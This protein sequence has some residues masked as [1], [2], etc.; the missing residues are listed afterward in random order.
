M[1]SAIFAIS[2]FI[3]ICGLNGPMKAQGGKQSTSSVA[4]SNC[5]NRSKILGSGKYKSIVIPESNK[6]PVLICLIGRNYFA[7]QVTQSLDFSQAPEPEP[8]TVPVPSEICDLF[9]NGQVGFYE[10]GGD[11]LECENFTVKSNGKT[12]CDFDTKIVYFV[13]IKGRYEIMGQTINRSRI[14]QLMREY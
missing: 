13:S 3:L 1:K 6:K 10:F 4:Q 11:D 12:P 7:G 9:K 8:G 2:L 14:L 5:T